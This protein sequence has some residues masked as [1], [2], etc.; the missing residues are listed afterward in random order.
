VDADEVA[1]HLNLAPPSCSAALSA[2]SAARLSDFDARGWR[3]YRAGEVDP[4]DA[5]QITFFCPE[6]A[7]REF[8]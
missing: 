8:G 1:R 5:A 3:A 4:D 6:C 2:V 7:E